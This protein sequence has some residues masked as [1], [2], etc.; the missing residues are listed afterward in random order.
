MP[1]TAVADGFRG[2]WL[3]LLALLAFLDLLPKSLRPAI[4]VTGSALFTY[5]ILKRRG[6][7]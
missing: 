4:T 3:G 7:L 1:K 6:W 5:R 2:D